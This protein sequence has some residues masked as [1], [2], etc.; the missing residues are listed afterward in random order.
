[1]RSLVLAASGLVGV[2]ANKHAFDTFTVVSRPVDL[3]YSEV[4]QRMQEPIELPQEIRDKYLGYDMAIRNFHVDVIERDPL[5]GAERSVPLSEAYNHHYI[6]FMGPKKTLDWLYEK[7]NEQM[8]PNDVTSPQQA[9]LLNADLN[10]HAEEEEDAQ[11]EEKEE[12]PMVIRQLDGHDLHMLG[13]CHGMGGRGMRMLQNKY[14]E[15][16]MDKVVQFGG[17]SGAEFRHNPHP[18][19]KPY[20]QVVKQPE[21]LA[22][23]LHLINTIDKDHE[24]EYSPLLECPC[25]PQRDFDLEHQKIDGKDPR[26]PFTCSKSM[27]EKGNTACR[28]ETYEGGFRCCEH[29]V[30]LVDTDKTDVYSSPAARF[31]F[32]FTFETERIKKSD[33]KK[34][35]E[36]A[37]ETAEGETH[38]LRGA[39]VRAAEGEEED[40]IPL[41]PVACCDV[42][43]DLE[44][45]GNIEYDVPQCPEGTPNERCLHVLSTVQYVDTWKSF[46]PYNV[47]ADPDDL[48]DLVYASAHIH[49]GGVRLDL[50]DEQT[51]QLLCSTEPQYGEGVDAGDEKNYVV[52]IKPCIWGPPPLP[53][54]PR[55]RKG[56]KLRTV[57][58][59]DASKKRHGV[60]SLWLMS[61][62]DVPKK[63]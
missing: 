31:F 16:S 35:A 10:Q 43:G 60:M 13:S 56:D 42:T 40:T 19:P 45:F 49:A 17:A 58:T 37:E 7:M 50:I 41:R 21:A 20:A 6:S 26:P 52:G 24:A 15:E 25:T 28:L 48:V 3:R 38:R 51:G 4:H 47:T 53:P 59:Y 11:S 33:E 1:M 8:D 36:A 14:G 29:G 61:G 9:A 23:I 34:A 27:L 39:L 55:F 2:C 63:A 57:A 54:P 32:K 22:A 18:Y 62:A 46:G 12:M 5:T 30:F 44:S